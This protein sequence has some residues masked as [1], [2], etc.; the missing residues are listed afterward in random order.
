MG[1][2]KRPPFS[3]PELTGERVGPWSG[4]PRREKANL[5]QG[6]L[7]AKSVKVGDEIKQ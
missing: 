7:I 6:A 1:A 3:I 5:G 4:H 2:W